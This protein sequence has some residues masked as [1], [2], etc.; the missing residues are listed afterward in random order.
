MVDKEQVLEAAA[1]IQPKRLMGARWAWP[2]RELEMQ[3]DLLR[4]APENGIDLD[5][6]RTR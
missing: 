1:Q 2:K 5:R 6:L 3:R 4:S